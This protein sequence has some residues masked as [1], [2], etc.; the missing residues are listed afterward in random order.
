MLQGQEADGRGWL[1]GSGSGRRQAHALIGVG[2][3][4]DL[5]GG[6]RHRGRIG[7]VVGGHRHR[8]VELLGGCHRLVGNSVIGYTIDQSGSRR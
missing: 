4:A 6:L 8:R 7:G 1:G 5:A 2:R 3:A